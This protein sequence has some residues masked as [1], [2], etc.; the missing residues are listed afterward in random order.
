MIH[1]NEF[2]SKPR[3]FRVI[4]ILQSTCDYTE[5]DDEEFAN[6]CFKVL[7]HERSCQTV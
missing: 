3:K 4:M 6:E 7:G 2:G 5:L 1:E